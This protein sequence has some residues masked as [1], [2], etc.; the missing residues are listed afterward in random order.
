MTLWVNTV[1]AQ[2]LGLAVRERGMTWDDLLGYAQRV[3][4]ARTAGDPTYLLYEAG[5][6][7]TT[8]FL[9]QALVR[10]RFPDLAQAVAKDGGPAKQ[11]ALRA[12][13]AEFAALG[14]CDPLLPGHRERVWHATRDLPLRD[15]C[16]F[17]VAGTWMYSHWRGIDA[18]AMERMH[19]CE[20]PTPVAVDHALGGYI[21]SWA[22]LA[23]APGREAA[24]Q[25]LMHWCSPD[26][27][28]RWTAYT[29]NPTGLR[30]DLER[31]RA[32][33]DPFE[34]FMLDM[35]AK[36]EER[37][38]MSSDP[39]FVLGPGGAVLGRALDEALCTLLEGHGDP[40]VLA[41]DLLRRAGEIR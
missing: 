18:L 6:W 7:L 41:D 3:Q 12:A 9:F 1:V 17:Y 11:G 35:D 27:A 30:G 25:L 34:R 33:Q 40:T 36:Y 29:K 19:P 13:F 10:S 20:L 22:V 5:D 2:R 4:H 15:A 14:R 39:A 26:V 23:K 38:R 8:G 16:L 37:V 24:V 31:L 21:P 28:N 32:A